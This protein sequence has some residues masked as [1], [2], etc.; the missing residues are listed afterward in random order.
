MDTGEGRGGCISMWRSSWRPSSGHLSCACQDVT[1]NCH[2]WR[3][4][5]GIQWRFGG[6][7]CLFFVCVFCFCCLYYFIFQV[8]IIGIDIC[9]FLIV[10]CLLFFSSFCVFVS[11]VLFFH[12]VICGLFF[13][14][15]SLS[16]FFQFS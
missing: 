5:G 16:H 3:D 1:A 10:I 2:A 13:R 15:F 8:G 12:L 11:V 6:C 14:F 9:D 7:Y 4:S